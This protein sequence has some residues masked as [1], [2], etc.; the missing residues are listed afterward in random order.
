MID[1]IV[2][3]VFNKFL[4]LNKYVSCVSD[5]F[6]NGIHHGMRQYAYSCQ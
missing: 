3:I 1:C 4:R 5:N 6:K 2:F